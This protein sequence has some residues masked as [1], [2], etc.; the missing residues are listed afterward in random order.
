[1]SSFESW[2]LSYLLNSL[3]QVP[4]LFAAGWLIAHALR[5]TGPAAEH[6]VWASVLMLQTALPAFSTLHWS[7]LRIPIPWDRAAS[8]INGAHVSIIMG[9]GTAPSAFHLPT[10]LLAT[11]TV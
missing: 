9:A 10:S 7:W 11:V 1:M 8:P 4:L 6:R 2:L 3:W 5:A